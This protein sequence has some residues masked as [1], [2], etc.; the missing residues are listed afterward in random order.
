MPELHQE[1]GQHIEA[2]R[3]TLAEETVAQQYERHPGLVEQYGPGGRDKCVADTSYHLSYL[4]AA[5]AAASPPLFLDYLAWAKVMMVAYQVRTEDVLENLVC[6]GEVLRRTLPGPMGA[7]AGEYVDAGLKHARTAPSSLP[8]LID[9]AEPNAALAKVYL[10]ALLC[11]DRQT[12]G[13]VVLDAVKAGVSVQ[14]IYLHVFQ[15]TQ[16]EIGR[17]WQMNLISVAQEHY[18]TAATQ[19]IMAQLYPYIFGTEKSGRRLVAACASGELHEI[20]MRIVTDFLEM[21][22]WDT[23]YLGANTPTSGIV[24]TVID[25]GAHV[26]AVS[27][28]MT[29]HIPVVAEVVRAL[30]SSPECAG[31]K[32]L[33]GGY[34]FHADPDLGKKIGADAQASDARNALAVVD[35]LVRGGR[36][37]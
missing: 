28:T 22:G 30:R 35:T 32:V 26:L 1:T 13:K 23:F 16:R 31:V 21:E 18:C 10:D 9:A 6:L 2:R 5:I 27:A 4:S 36:R 7:L 17:L 24:R 12:A 15:R 25:R 29:F 20:G 11:C 14:D 34:P 19:S 33:V 8:S 3:Q 37:S